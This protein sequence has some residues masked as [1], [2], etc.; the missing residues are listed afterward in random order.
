MKNKAITYVLLVSV[1]F[2]WGYIIYKFFFALPDDDENQFAQRKIINKQEVNLDHYRYK[3]TS[4]LQLNYADPMI[5][6]HTISRIDSNL[7]KTTAYI[8]PVMI[9]Q[10][11]KSYPNQPVIQV[12]YL[13]FIENI[14]TKKSTAIVKIENKQYM[15]NVGEGQKRVKLIAVNA[16]FIKVKIDGLIETIYKHEN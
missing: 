3:K 4:L 15:M 9:N 14:V 8:E 5:R 10:S 7:N 13:G 16:S 2:L 6:S 12:D 11:P 1:I